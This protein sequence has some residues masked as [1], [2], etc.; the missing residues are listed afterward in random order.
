M[1]DLNMS[2]ASRLEADAVGGGRAALGRVLRPRSV[3]FVGASASPVKVGGRR[4]LS[5][6]HAGFDGSLYPIH[7]TAREVA[8]IAALPSLLDVPVPLDLVVIAVPPGAVASVVDECAECRVGGV[9]L[10]T[11]GFG[12]HSAE[13]LALEQRFVSRLAKVDAR[14]IG[15]NCA[16]IFSAQGH[17]NVTG[18]V[19]PS[20]PIGLITQS[21][22]VMLDLAHRAR[23]SGVGFSHAISMGN[24]SDLRAPEL[25]SFML[26]DLETKVVLIYLEGWRAN[27][28]REMCDIVRRSGPT[29]PILLLKPGDTESG[30]RAVLSHTGS[31]AGELRV[32]EGAFVQ[33]GILKVASL[34]EA[35]ELAQGLSTL[36]LPPTSAVCVASDGGGHATLGCDAL[37]TA[38]LSVPT[39]S[40]ALQQKL[41]RLLPARCPIA[42]PI[43]YAGYAE[44]KPSVVAESLDIALSSDEVGAALLAGHFGGYHRLAGPEVKDAEV[45]AARK[46]AAIM[47]ARGKPI[48]VHSVYAEDKEPAIEVLRAGGVQVVRTLSAAAGLLGGLR[49]WSLV[50]SRSQLPP[51]APPQ[52]PDAA[53]AGPD[54]FPGAA[55]TGALPEPDA[56]RLV[57][58][59]GLQ[60]AASHLVRS[61]DECAAAVAGF[62]VPVALKVVSAAI[63]HKSDVG[64][65][66]L[67]IVA[68]TAAEGFDRLRA[69]GVG[70]GDMDAGVLVTPMVRPGLELVLGAVRD[71][72]FGP[73]VMLGFGGVLVEI[74]DDVVFR[75]APLSP[76]EAAT[77]PLALK[78][79]RLFA[80]HRN[81]SPVQTDALA[82]ALVRLSWL[83]ER[84]PQVQEV[85][86]N[87]AIANGDGLHFVDVRVIVRR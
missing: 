26:A 3:A 39:L 62:G 50:R 25:L 22:N 8:G 6:I 31:L 58:S 59:Y 32:G 73:V 24:G 71:P 15:P 20:G 64:G 4:W 72:H 54:D 66:L 9:V 76:G 44:E 7:P 1:E 68:A 16:G 47:M 30:R 53:P 69:V 42:N 45:D 13:G 35:W 60:V 65:V 55:S 67:N 83:I 86:I 38:G 87:P 49:R 11:G 29:K 36:P 2:A 5:M 19:L 12:E 57:A 85:D 51:E 70:A 56:R 78:A 40:N 81:T 80:G 48:V 82:D 41:A 21:G 18:M 63:L 23:R 34:D 27:E 84:E 79:S 77:M 43:D 33:A 52:I 10:I 37:E 28:A 61:R 46:M 75:M 14:L 74:L 17:V